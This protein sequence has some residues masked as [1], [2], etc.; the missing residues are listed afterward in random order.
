MFYGMPIHIIRDVA[1]TIRS[2]YKRVTDFVKYRQAT[3]DMNSRYPDATAE[4]IGDENVCIICREIMRLWQ[5]ADVRAGDEGTPPAG[6]VDER[7]RPKKLPCGHILHFA[8]L[9]SW[10]ERQQNCPTCRQPVLNATS[11]PHIPAG[12]A[13]QARAQAQHNIGAGALPGPANQ[14]RAIAGQNRIRFFNLGPIRLG[15]GAGQ[16]F[17]GRGPQ[18]REPAILEARRA[19]TRH[20]T[21]AQQFGLGLRP[22]HQQRANN[23][24]DNAPFSLTGVQ[25]QLQNIEQQLLREVHN[26]RLQA[27]QLNIIRALQAE[28]TRLRAA[29][30]LPDTS[31]V[32]N[33][34]QSPSAMYV[35]NVSTPT[36]TQPFNFDTQRERPMNVREA[37]PGVNVP[38]G[39]TLIPLRRLPT[40]PG[41]HHVPPVNVSHSG[42]SMP[43]ETA[44]APQTSARDLTT[45]DEVNQQNTRDQPSLTPS[46]SGNVP[47]GSPG[48]TSHTA[49]AQTTKYEPGGSPS[50]LED[51]NTL[52]EDRIDKS[53]LEHNNHMSTRSLELGASGGANTQMSRSA[54][55]WPEHRPRLSEWRERSHASG[56]RHSEMSVDSGAE[57]RE[58]KGKGRATTVEDA[59]E[60]E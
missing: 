29:Q 48:V 17:R 38:E 21:L 23:D 36:T 35:P 10:L 49:Q 40:G 30:L 20:D 46:L 4:E 50:P 31:N 37:L 54:S 58:A 43:R 9:R 12:V 45:S 11:I 42:I 8:C 25:T 28:L 51:A 41:L 59:G 34:S 27:D 52:L 32:N 13:G 3:R 19:P 5:P 56:P 55:D 1:L 18:V 7:L 22:G 39:W 53:S 47:G 26:L 14:Q 24:V 16:D 15:F 44:L 2:F 6:H 33:T 57:H 60:S